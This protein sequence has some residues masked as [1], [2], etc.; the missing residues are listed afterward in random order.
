[1][2]LLSC[3]STS[4]L[5]RQDAAWGGKTERC[6]VMLLCPFEMPGSCDAHMVLRGEKHRLSKES[7]PMIL[8]FLL[9][10][11]GTGQDGCCGSQTSGHP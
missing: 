2:Y 1:V 8:L 3:V 5:E 10:R 6:E 11:S 9:V 7:Q 4:P